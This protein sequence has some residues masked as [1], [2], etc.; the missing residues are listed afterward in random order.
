HEE[1]HAEDPGHA[2]EELAL[3]PAR[4]ASI[5]YVLGPFGWVL[6][7]LV[8]AAVI[9]YVA[10]I[11]PVTVFEGALAEEGRRIPGD[12]SGGHQ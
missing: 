12:E 6:E 2:A 5:V 1:A 11:R 3:S 7:A 9:G 8:T 4:F 10:R